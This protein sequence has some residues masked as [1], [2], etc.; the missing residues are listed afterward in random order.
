MEKDFFEKQI[1]DYINGSLSKESKKAFEAQLAK[2]S[3][4]A[5]ELNFRQQLSQSVQQVTETETNQAISEMVSSL[6]QEGYFEKLSNEFNQNQPNKKGLKDNNKKILKLWPRILTIAASLLL[7][8]GV[9]F[10]FWAK[11]NYSNQALAQHSLTGSQMET[12]LRSNQNN[13]DIFEEGILALNQN[14]FTK[15]ISF[16]KTIESTDNAFPDALLLLS[17]AQF[18]IGNYEEAISNSQQL[19]T[20]NTHLN[21]K[22]NWIQLNAKL[23]ANQLDEKFYQLLTQLIQDNN[24]PYYQQKALQLKNDLDSIWRKLPI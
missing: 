24:D 19:V 6:E 11:Q 7:L 8:I 10:W 2:D 17:I 15:A 20:R 22:A 14:N 23:A 3:N 9:A 13:A 16:F 4:L 5:N 12:L 21:S 18:K 1:D